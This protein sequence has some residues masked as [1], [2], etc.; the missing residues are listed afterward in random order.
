MGTPRTRPPRSARGSALS[1]ASGTRRAR[2]WRGRAQALHEED[3][4]LRPAL[5]D[6]R[7]VAMSRN[8]LACVLLERGD[9]AGAITLL[10][11]DLRLVQGVGVRRGIAMVLSPVA[12][13]GHERERATALPG[14]SLTLFH[15]PGNRIDIAL[16]LD[17][18]AALTAAA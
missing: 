2:S 13:A 10:E 14:E 4:T 15:R 12:I 9:R 8:S 17:R 1:A 16:C 3:L 18:L 11:E 6:P 7:G 5:E